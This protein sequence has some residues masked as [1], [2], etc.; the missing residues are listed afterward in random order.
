[1]LAF[2]PLIYKKSSL[3]AAPAEQRHLFIGCAQLANEMV[4]LQRQMRAARNALDASTEKV[5]AEMATATML[6]CLRLLIAR[7]LEL[8]NFAHAA[9]GE[10]KRLA[11]VALAVRPDIAAELAKAD[12]GLSVLDTAWGDGRTTQAVMIR[13]KLAFHLRPEAIEMALAAMPDDQDL[14]DLLSVRRVN[15]IYSSAEAAHVYALC[16]VLDQASP[17]GA[18]EAAME[19]ARELMSAASDFAD[20]YA[21]A[22]ACAY[23]GPGVLHPDI[24]IAEPAPL[25]DGLFFSSTEV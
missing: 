13:N 22:F 1:M 16:S 15:A 24:E 19:L 2:T 3:A 18:L 17:M 10:R 21:L 7:A 14:V 11:D 8:R 9:R 5:A 4:I 6:F 23:L 25:M 20:G 12:E